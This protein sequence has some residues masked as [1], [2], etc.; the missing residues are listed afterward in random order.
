M[1]KI[2]K[3]KPIVWL[4]CIALILCA[5]T[6]AMHKK[7]QEQV[8][9]QL[10]PVQIAGHIADV[11]GGGP[12]E[13]RKRTRNKWR[14]LRVWFGRDQHDVSGEITEFLDPSDTQLAVRASRALARLER[15][16]AESALK[17]T[18]QHLTPFK[19]QF[20]EIPLRSALAR[21]QTRQLRGSTRIEAVSRDFDLSLNGLAELSRRVNAPK[22]MLGGTKGAQILEEIV[23]LLY[24]MADRGENI[25][26]I[27]Q[28]LTLH[29][30]HMTRLRAAP[31]PVKQEAQMILDYLSQVEMQ[32]GPDNDLANV[33]LIE[34]GPQV[35]DVI[36][37]ALED[38]AR[39]P[40]KYSGR[41]PNP[42]YPGSHFEQQSYRSIFE[43]AASSGDERTV[44]L[45]Q[46]IEG[47]KQPHLRVNFQARQSR[48]FLKLEQFFLSGTPTRSYVVP[49]QQ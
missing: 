26:R 15:P 6:L 41:K 19:K 37:K 46:Q 18:Q 22:A 25:D 13:L 12:E 36:V 44:P 30:A 29:P 8:L 43:A 17:E 14:Y 45:F 27:V 38:V 31:L 2:L 5:G 16:G 3:Q 49:T 24:S 10:L 47:A 40:E 4:S 28:R 34:L 23:D 7:H 1:L 42:S 35:N 48:E 33:Y 11:D 20:L 9:E 39:H 32:T 21:I